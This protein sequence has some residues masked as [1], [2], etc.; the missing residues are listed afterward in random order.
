MPRKFKLTSGVKNAA[1]RVLSVKAPPKPKVKKSTM[2]VTTLKG[3]P[4][5][6]KFKASSAMGSLSSATTQA[7]QELR[8]RL[9][10]RA[11]EIRAAKKKAPPMARPD[12]KVKRKSSLSM[13]ELKKKRD[14][15]IKK[16]IRSIKK[17]PRPKL[18]SL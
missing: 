10:K 1:K 15:Q 18:K 12:N 7:E 6:A 17:H 2:T 14:E 8:A 16:S 3:K 13:A 4:K 9:K 11:N 5:A